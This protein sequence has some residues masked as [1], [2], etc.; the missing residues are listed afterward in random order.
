MTESQALHRLAAY[1]SRAERCESDISKK[2]LAWELTA[3]S[4]LRIVTRLKT[5]K[6][7]D[8]TRYARAF[9][10]DKS[11]FGKWGQI[12]IE[13]ELRKKRIPERIIAEAILELNQETTASVLHDLLMKKNTTVKARD[14]YDR[15]TKLIRFAASKGYALDD[16]IRNLDK[17]LNQQDGDME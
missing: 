14:Y 13:F 9:V 3:D 16:I 10:R 15:K 1:C 5:E 2:L 8:E 17:I 6:F 11:R 7:L 12:K 4:C